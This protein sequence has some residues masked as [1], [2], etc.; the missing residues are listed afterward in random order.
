MPEPWASL[1]GHDRTRQGNCRSGE[2]QLDR[3]CLTRRMDL[4]QLFG[5]VARPSIDL[6]LSLIDMFHRGE[7]IAKSQSQRR[8]AE[9]GETIADARDEAMIVCEQC[10]EQSI[11]LSATVADV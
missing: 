10:G 3:A 9:L 7:D 6:R 11:V 4:A 8:S 5:A 1:S 2:M